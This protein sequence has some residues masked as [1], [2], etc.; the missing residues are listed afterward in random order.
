MY[1]DNRSRRPVSLRHDYLRRSWCLREDRRRRRGLLL[2]STWLT[3]LRLA[4]TFLTIFPLARNLNWEPSDVSNSRAF[5]P[6]VGLLMGLLLVGVEEGSSQLFSAPMT[7]AFLVA[8]MVIITR[9]FHLDGLMDICDGVFGGFTPERRLEIMKDSRVGAFGVAGGVV[10]L[11]LKYA[12]FVTL[13][14]IPEPGKV[15]ALLLFPAISRW[16]MVVLLGAFPYVRTHGLGSPF[17]GSGIKV[18]TAIAGISILSAAILLGGF[19]GLGLLIGA[20]VMAWIMGWGMAKSLGGLT[21]DAYGATNEIIE[22]TVIIVATALAAQEWLEP[23][24][25]LLERF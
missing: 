14:T 2:I 12:A 19:A 1:A 4:V 23:L 24:P 7:A 22:M 11:L 25:D 5:Y 10:V 17:H 8:A 16:T 21:G 9:A 15:W 3:P 20:M 13:L 6:A 18:S